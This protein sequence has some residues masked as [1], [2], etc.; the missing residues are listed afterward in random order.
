MIENLNV[1]ELKELKRYRVV[2]EFDLN[3][4]IGC[5]TI[6]EFISSA[7]AKEVPV[8]EELIKIMID[9]ATGWLG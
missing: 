4:Y 6:V 2:D 5:A 9:V 3:Y 7:N 1:N 8:S